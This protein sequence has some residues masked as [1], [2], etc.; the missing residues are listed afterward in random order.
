MTRVR[1]PGSEKVRILTYH[2]IGV[3]RS[4]RYERLTVSPGRFRAQLELMRWTG[5]RFADLDETAAWLG[6]GTGRIG[7][8]VVLSFDDGYADLYEHALPRLLERG[9]PAIVFLV[10][11]RNV[12]AWMDWGERGS[13]ELLSWT[14]IRE[15]SDA[16]IQF[17]SHSLTHPDL[18]GLEPGALT[19]EVRDSKKRIEDRIGCE[20][21]H[22][23]YPFGAQSPTV[24]D[25]V[26]E[27]GYTSAC[28][29]RRAAVR[30]G[31]DAFL[32]PRLSV[33]KRMGLGR[34]TLRL[35]FRH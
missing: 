26:R 12:D 17:G 5:V 24:V 14:Q 29:T 2:R 16:G 6:G 31:E 27:A 11:E 30:E 25:A 3:P 10:A 32:L 4:G 28:T 21:R 35:S 19:A 1:S 22:F 7:R 33:G 18:T 15:L 20:V 8:P 23:C 9:L 34:F 13:L